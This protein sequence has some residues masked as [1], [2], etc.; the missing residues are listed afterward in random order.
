MVD[1]YHLA[2]TCA[3]P[4][5]GHLVI[6]WYEVY[7]K[8]NMVLSSPNSKDVVSD[9]PSRVTFLGEALEPVAK[10]LR[11]AMARK[12]RSSGHEFVTIDDVS[13]HMGVISQALTHLSPKFE[14]LMVNVMRNESAGMAEACRAAGRLEQVLSEFVDGYHEVKA[15]HAGAETTEARNLLLG[16]YRHHIREICEWLEELVQA[17]ANPVSAMKK[18]G[19]PLTANVEL[20]VILTMTSPPEMDKLNDLA[21]RLQIKLAPVIEPAP[22]PAPRYEPPQSRGPGVLGTIGALAFGV[23]IHQAIWRHHRG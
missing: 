21:Q 9:L 7:S 8:G 20:S 17:I 4:G 23:G 3:D 19:I 13:R 14:D 5:L 18:R 6:K 10:D 2:A 22:T 12:V 1:G 16:M 15:S 11:Q